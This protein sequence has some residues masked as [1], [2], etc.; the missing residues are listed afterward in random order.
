MRDAL[1]LSLFA[2]VFLA[3]AVV[4]GVVALLL[5]FS[6]IEISYPVTEHQAVIIVA[7]FLVS[8]AI[9]VLIDYVLA[10]ITGA[11]FNIFVSVGTALA[12]GAIGKGIGLGISAVRRSPN[13]IRL[14]QAAARRG[15][16]EHKAWM[17]MAREALNSAGRVEGFCP[18]CFTLDKGIRDFAGKVWRNGANKYARPDMV[19][20]ANHL[21]MDLKPVPK[22][23]FDA[24][25][26]VMEKYLNTTYAAQKAFYI[27]AYHQARG[28][29][30]ESISFAWD[31]YVK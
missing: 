20:Y 27:E 8:L 11:E 1:T 28:V 13:T 23:I 21:I 2:R 19:D 10:K 7:G 24:G 15:V 4:L 3:N 14:L 18:T 12:F 31:V 9:N 6:P 25:E 29:A 17:K 22:A 5:L 30:K 16:A 26:E